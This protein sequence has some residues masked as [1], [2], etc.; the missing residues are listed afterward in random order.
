MEDEFSELPVKP[1][2]DRE[3]ENIRNKSRRGQASFQKS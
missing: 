3:S 1:V 2:G